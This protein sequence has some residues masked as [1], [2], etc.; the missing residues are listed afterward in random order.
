MQHDAGQGKA[1]ALD[2]PGANIARARF[3]R[4]DE[5]NTLNFDAITEL[6]RAIDAVEAGRGRVLILTGEGSAFCAGAHLKYF[7]DADSPL[8]TPVAIRDRYLVPITRLFER[9][10]AAPFA[11]I[12]AINGYALGGGLELALSCDFRVM[13]AD[14]RIGLPEVRIG[15]FPAAG[16]V[17]KLHRL[18]GRGKALEL[19]LLGRQVNASEA[20]RLGLV[21]AVVEP[22]ALET[23]VM[24]LCLEICK[25]GR[26]AVA[27]AKA[28]IYYS[29]NV[30]IRS[31]RDFGLESLT[32]LAGLSE[33]A[34]GMAAFVGKRKPRFD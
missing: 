15:A 18:I 27:Q 6:N 16:G 5:R 17:Q 24:E 20:D 26:S 1:V 11:T 14:A 19:I 34:E 23:A 13:A 2:W 10:E 12:A 30:D 28:N 8:N 7:T 33:W 32:V 9:L 3:T 29:E 25:G 31:A 22:A 21:Y 4:P